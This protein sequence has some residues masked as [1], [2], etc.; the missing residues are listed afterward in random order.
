M[1]ER[2]RSLF[3]EDNVDPGIYLKGLRKPMKTFI[4]DSRSAGHDLNP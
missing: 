3:L 2:A 4:Q 1:S